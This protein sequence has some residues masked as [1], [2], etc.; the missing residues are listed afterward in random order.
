MPLNSLA[1]SSFP[2]MTGILGEGAGVGVF[3][4]SSIS[5]GVSGTTWARC[6]C[7]SEIQRSTMAVNAAASRSK[8]KKR[9]VLSRIF[10]TPVELF[11]DPGDDRDDD[12]DCA[13]HRH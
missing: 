5:T 7:S 1:V 10:R 6:H 13:Q 8:T 11:L 9:S 12:A 4:G 3:S 2:V